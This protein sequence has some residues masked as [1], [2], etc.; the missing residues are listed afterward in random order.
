[1]ILFVWA[2]RLVTVQTYGPT[3]YS[4]WHDEPLWFEIQKRLKRK[5]AEEVHR[6]KGPVEGSI[7]APFSE[8]TKKGSFKDRY[9][10][11]TLL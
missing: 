2:E 3:L 10:I 1:M 8:V 7:Q 9:N 5:K 11:H 4:Y 6:L